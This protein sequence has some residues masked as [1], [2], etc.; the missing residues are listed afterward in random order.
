MD[1]LP[2]IG[3]SGR[4]LSESQANLSF[5][6]SNLEYNVAAILVEFRNNTT[7]VTFPA[8]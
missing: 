6:A 1:P 8:L 5:F 4:L 3:P 2:E 7:S